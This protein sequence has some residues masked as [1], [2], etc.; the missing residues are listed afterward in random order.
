MALQKSKKYSA[1][2]IYSCFGDSAFTALKRDEK[3]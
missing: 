1:F 3:F 2:V